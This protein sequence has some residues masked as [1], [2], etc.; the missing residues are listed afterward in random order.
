MESKYQY[1]LSQKA[2]ADLDGIVS[3]HTLQWSCQIHRRHRT[4]SI[5]WEK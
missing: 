5:S 1:R 3:F 4:L 2:E